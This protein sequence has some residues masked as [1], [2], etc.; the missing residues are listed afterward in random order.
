M[1]YTFSQMLSISNP[2][3]PLAKHFM[4]VVEKRDIGIKM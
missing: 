2:A 4:K 1:F 3:K